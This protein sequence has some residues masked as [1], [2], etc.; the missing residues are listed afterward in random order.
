MEIYPV[1]PSIIGF[2]RNIFKRFFCDGHKH[3]GL[4]YNEFT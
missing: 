1:L 3:S 2:Y 4:G